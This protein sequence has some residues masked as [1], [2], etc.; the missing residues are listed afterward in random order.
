MII[1]VA[2]EGARSGGGEKG[3]N[4]GPVWKEES[5]RRA[6]VLNVR[7]ERKR[8]VMNNFKVLVLNTVS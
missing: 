5:T 8:G 7:Y 2:D 6:D 1:Q 3:S 4:V